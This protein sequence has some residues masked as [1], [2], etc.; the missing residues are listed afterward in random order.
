MKLAEI[1]AKLGAKIA[2]ENVI[3]IVRGNQFPAKLI[4]ATL[5]ETTLKPVL[6][7]EA[8]IPV[9]ER[10]PRKAEDVKPGKK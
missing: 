1:E 7:F 10:K 2:T 3:V 5:S 9:V 6:V 4:T 8:D